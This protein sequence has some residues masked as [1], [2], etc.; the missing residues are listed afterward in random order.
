M[1]NVVDCM[2]SWTQCFCFVCVCDCPSKRLFINL[3]VLVH[4]DLIQRRPQSPY[5]SCVCAAV[6]HISAVGASSCV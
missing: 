2:L 1:A 6:S 3:F 5:I 4:R